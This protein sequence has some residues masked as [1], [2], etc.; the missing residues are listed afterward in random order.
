[1]KQNQ[2]QIPEFEDI[3]NKKKENTEES[4]NWFRAFF[5]GTY[6]GKESFIKHFPFVLFISLLGL[7]YIA[8]TYHAE[9]LVR[10][11]E[12]LNKTIREL[13]TEATS[14]SSQ[15]MQMSN[16]SAISNLCREKN[17]ELY[18]SIEPPYKIVLTKDDIS[19][20]E[21]KKLKNK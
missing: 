13:G 2:K 16:Q 18:E 8:N 9:Y 17:M 3:A 7:V 15:L 14:I 11:Y 19:I 4:K 10:K 21:L 6:L 5:D 12:S 20:I 1:M